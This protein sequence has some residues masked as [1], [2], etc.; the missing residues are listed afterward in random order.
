[1]N[2]DYRD[3]IAKAYRNALGVVCSVA[4]ADLIFSNYN[5][6]TDLL[7]VHRRPDVYSS[8]GHA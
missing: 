2:D 3:A 4:G 7:L 5:S 6:S 8:L 1:M